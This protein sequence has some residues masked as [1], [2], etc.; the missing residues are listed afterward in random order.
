[1]IGDGVLVFCPIGDSDIKRNRLDG[2]VVSRE[3][4]GDI[5]GIAA[6]IDRRAAT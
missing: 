4:E 1:M 3:I 6:Q 5:V 2:E